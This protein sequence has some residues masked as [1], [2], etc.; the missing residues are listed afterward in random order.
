MKAS[1]ILSGLIYAHLKISHPEGGVEKI[2]AMEGS[3]EIVYI[4]LDFIAPEHYHRKEY[5]QIHRIPIR[6]RLDE[7]VYEHLVDQEQYSRYLD[8]YRKNKD[9]SLNNIDQHILRKHYYPRALRTLKKK[10]NF[11]L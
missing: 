5:Y 1:D 4:F 10:K 3:P 8:L 6:S 11:N 2:A 7:W 9:I